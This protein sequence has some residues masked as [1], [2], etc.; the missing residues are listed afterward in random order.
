MAS[1]GR[2]VRPRKMT[3]SCWGAE[4]GTARD[5]PTRSAEGA[6]LDPEFAGRETPARGVRSE[7]QDKEARRAGGLLRAIAGRA[8]GWPWSGHGENQAPHLLLPRQ[9][10]PLAEG[11]TWSLRLQQKQQGT[12]RGGIGRER[13]K[14]WRR[15]TGGAWA[16]AETE[17]EGRA[18]LRGNERRV[19]GRGP[20]GGWS[21]GRAGAGKR[22]RPNPAA[23][24]RPYACAGTPSAPPTTWGCAL[25]DGVLGIVVLRSLGPPPTGLVL[26]THLGQGMKR[27]GRGFSRLFD[28]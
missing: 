3:T 10:L 25:S 1:P 5:R 15:E 20:T 2:G 18:E 7:P 9:P 24:R 13:T 12:R 21:A 27:E 16:L 4:E 8:A 6:A 19:C 23:T 26:R 22:T 28:R 11:K 14:P 17:K